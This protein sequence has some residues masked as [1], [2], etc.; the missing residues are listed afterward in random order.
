MALSTFDDIKASI[1]KWAERSDIADE[2]ITDF[3]YMAEADASQ[4]LRVPAMEHAIQLHVTSGRVTIP[5]DFLELRRLT[6]EGSND[7]SLQYLPWDQFVV[8]NRDTT[9]DPKYFSRQGP[10]WF[11]HGEPSDGDVILCYYY[12]YVPAL[13]TDSQ[14]NWLLTVSPQVYLF[15]GLKYLYE[16]TMDNERAAYWGAKLDKELNKLQAI[17]DLAEH[18]GSTLSVKNI[19]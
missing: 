16:Y 18:R 11:I 14:I 12:R 5:F 10:N 3:L 6:W 19:S 17:A 1:V 8:E 15:G 9:G 13:T 2:L 4:Q 7:T